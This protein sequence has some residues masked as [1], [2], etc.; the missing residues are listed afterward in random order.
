MGLF[1]RKKKFVPTYTVFGKATQD[2][3]VSLAMSEMDV[4][5][6]TWFFSYLQ[7]WCE[8]QSYI[9]NG[10]TQVNPRRVGTDLATRLYFLNF[11]S[12]TRVNELESLLSTLVD[13]EDDRAMTRILDLYAAVIATTD[14]DY[15]T[16][17]ITR[18]YNALETL[19]DTEAE[20]DWR[21]IHREYP[22]MWL[23]HMLHI[24][25]QN[26]PTAPGQS[27]PEALPT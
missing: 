11:R 5:Q 8:Q 9:K 27:A 7:R 12:L 15:L 16:R 19:L 25:L 26:H 4:R 20:V 13:N 14:A 21:Y 23:L 24:V 1:T 18:L 17:M 10:V 6:Q 22:Y 2:G 3:P